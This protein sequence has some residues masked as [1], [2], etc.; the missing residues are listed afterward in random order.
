MF[1]KLI[2]F[3]V[4]TRAVPTAEQYRRVAQQQGCAIPNQPN[5]CDKNLCYHAR[6]RTAD[7]SCNHLSDSLKGASFMPFVRMLNANFE[8]GLNAMVGSQSN[9]RPS[10]RMLTRFLMGSPKSLPTKASSLVTAYGQFLMHDL[11]RNTL[12]NTCK[13]NTQGAHCANIPLVNGDKR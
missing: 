4:Q 1:L 12:V 3:L 11:M 13:C 10:P 5:Q 8:D 9:S 2:L 7:G 6:Y